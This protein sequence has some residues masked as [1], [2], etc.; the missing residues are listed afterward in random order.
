MQA[1]GP[2]DVLRLVRGVAQSDPGAFPSL[3]ELLTGREYFGLTEATPL[4]RA[5]CRI[6]EGRPL[7]E[8]GTHPDVISGLGGEDAV[9]AMPAEPPAE[10]CLLA[11]IR[12][13]KSLLTAANAVRASQVCDLSR[14]GPG[15]IP[16]I[17]VVS[18]KM[19]LAQV[20][21]RH[22]VGNVQASPRLR[23]LVIGEPTADTIL[24]RH[25]SGRPVEIKVTAGAR[26]GSTLVA[27][28]LAGVV[29]DEA[30]RMIGADDGVVNLEDMRS[31]ILGRLLPGAQVLYPGSPWAPFGPVYQ[32]VTERWGSPGRDLVVIRGTG[33]QMNPSHWTPERCDELRERDPDAHA[34]DVL[35]QFL[36]PESS[37]FD[38]K[39]I[40]ASATG[41]LDAAPVE[42]YQYVAAIDPATRGNAWTLVLGAC[43]G[44]RNG[45]RHVTVP[46]ARQWI[47]SKVAPLQPTVVLRD[48]SDL[49]ERYG[50]RVIVTDQYAADALRDLGHLHGVSLIE[51]PW[52][53]ATKLDAFDSMR[54]RLV[55]GL[56]ELPPDEALIRDLLTVRRRV[57]QQS[58][59]IDLPRTPDGRHCDYAPALAALLAQPMSE[60]VKVERVP[61]AGRERQ[62]YDW[63]KRIERDEEREAA[64]LRAFGGA[65]FE[66]VTAQEV[67]L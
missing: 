59:S 36:S 47:G 64:M 26:A 49:C 37:L 2:A 9:T 38:E 13:A 30:P 40:R 20:V 24:L 34:T 17:P 58:V 51:R 12:S 11:A 56:V 29:F 7:A 10:V 46:L 52:T 39:T 19:D 43:T 4:Q 48:I 1:A 18:L 16:R 53:S 55:T 54:V 61:D 28:W 35:G 6:V 44:R 21:F 22:I 5:V 15:E 57:T 3:E 41:A 32:M 65:G 27:R 31:A 67:G 62:A 63:R 60:P 14:L 8:L 33:P 25:P 42:G 23:A 45:M 50:V 66:P